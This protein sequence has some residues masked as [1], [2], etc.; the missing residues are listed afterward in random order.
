[1]NFQVPEGVLNQF[2]STG[3]FIVSGA[4]S[5]TSVD[6]LDV[7]SE[8]PI[9]G[10]VSGIYV[11]S[12]NAYDL[13]WRTATF[14][15]YSG[16]PDVANNTGANWLRSIYYNENPIIDSN[17]QYNFQRVDTSVSYGAPNGA[18]INQTTPQLMVTRQASEILRAS[19]VNADGI[20]SNFNSDFIKYYTIANT[21]CI[22]VIV[23]VKVNQLLEQ[24]SISNDK[25]YGDILSTGVAYSIYYKPLFSDSSNFNTTSNA[26]N[27]TKDDVNFIKGA[28]DSIIG[29]ITQGYIRS[30][31]V[32]FD[33]NYLKRPDF[34][35]WQLKII[36]TTPDSTTSFIQNQTFI[37]SLVELYA[38]VFTYPNTAV[39]RS[40]FNAQF[41]SQIPRRAFDT[42]LLKVLIP[43]NY[44]P[45]LKN[46]N[47]GTN[48]WDGTFATQKTWTDNPAWCFFDLVTNPRYGLGQYVDTTMIDKWTLYEIG[49]YCD[50]LVPDGF[51]HLEPR[52]SC[53]LIINSRDDAYKV[54]SDFT[55][56]FRAINYY[57]AG[58]IYVVQDSPKPINTIFTNSNVENGD[59]Q[60]SSSSKKARHTVAVVRYNDKTNFYKPAVEYIEDINGIRRYGIREL[61]M[62]AFGCTSRGQAVRFGRWALLSETLETETVSFTAGLEGARVRI[63][64]VFGVYDTNRKL[65][66]NAGRTFQINSG[67]AGIAGYSGYM[68][69]HVVTLDRIITP[70]S[71]TYYNFS[72]LCPT[73]E[74]DPSLISNLSGIDYSGI[75]HSQLQI[76]PFSGYQAS[77]TGI[78]SGTQIFFTGFFDTINHDLQ[79]NLVWSISL[80]SGVANLGQ[81]TQTI[82]PN[83]DYYRII[84]VQEK[85]EN[86]Y[87]VVGLQYAEQKYIEIESGLGFERAQS[88][89]AFTPTIASALYVSTRQRGKSAD[90][91]AFSFVMPN[92]TGVTS[93]KVYAINGNFP[94]NNIPS[95]NYLVANLP[96]GTT[97]GSFITKNSGFHNLRIYSFNDQSNTF[98]SSFITGGVN[99]VINNQILDIQIGSLRFDGNITSY[100]T[101][102]PTN[103]TGYLNSINPKFSWQIGNLSTTVSGGMN[104][105]ISIRSPSNSNTPSSTIYYQE[106]GWQTSISNPNYIFTFDKNINSLGGPYRNYDIIIEAIDSKGNTSAG[107]NINNP[108]DNNW[109]LYP[110]GYDIMNVNHPL[111]TGITLSSGGINPSTFATEQ[112]IDIDGTPKIRFT[113][114]NFPSEIKGGFI[115]VST[116]IFDKINI[117]GSN[118]IAFPIYT[119]EFNYNG[120]IN[121]WIYS[122]KIKIPQVTTGYIGISFYDDLDFLILSKNS[123]TYLTGAWIS[124]VVPIVSSGQL[125]FLDIYNT[126]TFND[127]QFDNNK[128]FLTR[129]VTGGNTYVVHQGQD[130]KGNSIIISSKQL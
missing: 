61:D 57:G 10:L 128:M 93:H 119:G 43:S 27:P 50:T 122:P 94:D 71:N 114:G 54:I 39:I 72:L 98:S 4:L 121:D 15:A 64:D 52:F 82:D 111:V 12:G 60:Y 75:R 22:G 63:G 113:S 101:F 33:N 109:S 117:T 20:S 53:N 51:G 26:L 19:V 49:K 85:E 13:G 78:N 29:K 59:F 89:Y 84:N 96:A 35:G 69:G 100:S 97:N 38:D 116:G 115:Y 68:A 67:V 42:K 11:F 28:D 55:S 1:M 70:N 86:K 104:H 92:Y 34:I 110:Y 106:T 48:G 9:E 99:S 14:Q 79:N 112:F 2:D 56:V 66:S 41:F 23:N 30:T 8:G 83:Y 17:N 32:N 120:S 31:K 36:R 45:I 44:D 103:K 73:Y 130:H 118:G 58:K 81:S 77:G 124:N 91:I 105:R 126:L 6:V 127:F 47:E 37:D 107:N 108:P 87:N 5:V 21:E 16:V 7:L 18:I 102:G 46:Y 24:D 125:G 3:G 76:M 25:N 62:T 123:S 95:N 65:A 90:E 74:Y 80:Y 129:T 40:K 88:L